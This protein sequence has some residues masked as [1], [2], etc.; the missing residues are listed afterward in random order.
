MLQ[1]IKEKI[2]DILKT[3]YIEDSPDLILEL[4]EQEKQR[5]WN[6]GFLTG[7]KLEKTRCQEEKQKVVEEILKS[8]EDYPYT[9]YIDL[10]ELKQKL[11]PK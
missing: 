8:L 3:N 2:S 1:E 7:K 6:K 11:N 10:E 9:H 4:F 5:G